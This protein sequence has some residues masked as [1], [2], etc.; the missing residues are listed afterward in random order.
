M[1][2]VYTIG[3]SLYEIVFVDG[4]PTYVTPGGGMLNVAISLG[5][6]GIP[7]NLISEIGMDPP[8]R[9][10]EEFLVDS[11]IGIEN[12]HHYRDYPT[13]VSLAFLDQ[14]KQATYTFCKQFPDKRLEGP[15]PDFQ[16]ND[17]L[18]FSSS[19]GVNPAARSNLIRVVQH[20]RERGA[21]V[22]YDPNVRKV[23]SL[24][25]ITLL[26]W[27]RANIRYADIIRSSEEDFA[28]LR[29]LEGDA[30]N[31][32]DEGEELDETYGL[33]G[34]LKLRGDQVLIETQG[35]KGV[36]LWKQGMA[37]HLDAPVIEPVSTIGAGD[38]FQSGVLCELYQTDVTRDQVAT[39]EKAD[40]ERILQR[41]IDFATE[42]CMSQENFVK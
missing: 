32:I 40:W 14:E 3:E 10:L 11:H 15:V 27:H 25:A 35:A 42:V 20:A 41:G 26:R 37:L 23:S 34:W 17:I 2:Q 28:M 6:K 38:A 18:L 8:G 7:V 4:K 13:A 5:R 30:T 12:L 21:L 9:F 19:F 22:L 39:L 29:A 24:D 31:P 1:R 33:Y 16:A 36:Y